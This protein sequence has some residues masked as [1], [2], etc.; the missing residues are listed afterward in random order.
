MSLGTIPRETANKK[1]IEAESQ[2]VE[3]KWERRKAARAQ[4]TTASKVAGYCDWV[5]S[6]R[7]TEAHVVHDE[8]RRH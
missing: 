4:T 8:A 6:A 7:L 5:K 2:R 1:E 3:R